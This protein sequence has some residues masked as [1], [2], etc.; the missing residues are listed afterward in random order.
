MKKM[1]KRIL[2]GIAILA[3]TVIA[4]ITAIGYKMYRKALYEKPL[5]VAVAEIRSK[6]AF[7]EIGELPEI[8]LN[9]IIAVEDHRFYS[10]PG[11]DI[12]ATARAA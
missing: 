8:Y 7:T 10:H 4:V 12:I 11:V 2:L 3:F 9:A 6:A 5:N 1:I